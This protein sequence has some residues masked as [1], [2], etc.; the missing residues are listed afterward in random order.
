MRHSFIFR[1]LLGTILLAVTALPH[2]ADKYPSRPIKIVANMAAGGGTDGIAR[3]FAQRLSSELGQPVIVE[4][5]AGAAGQIGTEFVATTPGDGYTFLF[6]SSTLQ[7]LPY[8][9]KTRYEILKDFAPIGQVGVGGFVLVV[10]PKSKFKS[11]GEFL[12]QVK[13]HPGKYTVGTSGIGSAGHLGLYLLRS[14]AGIDM[15]HVPFKSSTEVV[16]ALISGQIDCSLDIVPIEKPFVDAGSV[17]ALATTRDSRDPSLPG[18]PTFNE[19]KQI[20]GGFE[21]I[22]WY[23]MFAPRNT[24]PAIVKKAQLAFATAL[25]DPATQERVRTYSLSPSHL[26]AAEFEKSIAGEVVLWRKIIKDYDIKID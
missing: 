24:P 23:G 6:A 8:L 3:I 17:R 26:T 18:V 5:R 19:S 13:S 15:V 21:L 10:N 16:Q 14:K 25:A 22:F 20:P 9:R 2:A 11:L 4:N 7:S 1:C 12:A